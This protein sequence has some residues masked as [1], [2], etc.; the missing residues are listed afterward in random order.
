MLVNIFRVKEAANKSVLAKFKFK[1]KK[2][3]DETRGVLKM[4]FRGFYPHPY[5]PGVTIS[6]GDTISFAEL[7]SVTSPVSNTYIVQQ[8][9]CS[10]VSV[11]LLWEC[12]E[13]VL[14]S[15]PRIP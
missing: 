1:Q 10:G 3:L 15:S 4:C 2:K 6:T 14:K 7:V 12:Q 9:G 5:S 11:E 13:V 8:R